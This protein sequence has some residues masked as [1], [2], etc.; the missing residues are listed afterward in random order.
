MSARNREFVKKLIAWAIIVTMLMSTVVFLIIVIMQQ[1][2][3][4]M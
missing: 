2:Q 4:G 1:S 3:L